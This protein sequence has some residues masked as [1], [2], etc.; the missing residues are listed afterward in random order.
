MLCS[1]DQ[2]E[3][4]WGVERILAIRGDRDPDA[5]LGATSHLLSKHVRASNFTLDIDDVV[6]SLMDVKKSK[7]DPIFDGPF[8][9]IA[10]EHG[11][12]LFVCVVLLLSRR[13]HLVGVT[14]PYRDTYLH[15]STICGEVYSL[16]IWCEREVSEQDKVAAAEHLG[17]SWSSLGRA[18]G[19]SAGQLDNIAADFPRV[20]DRSFELLQRWHDREAERATLAALTKYLLDSR[21]LAAV[22]NLR[23]C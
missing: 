2:K 17:V 20:A 3:R 12:K 11:N 23:P 15:D 19:F 8:R 16:G 18:M 22:K 6:Y 10:K 4:I 1:E 9:V 13:G 21:A 7:L 14:E 5:Q